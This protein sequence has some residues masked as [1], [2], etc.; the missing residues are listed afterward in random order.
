MAY[1]VAQAGSNWNKWK[2]MEIESGK[3]LEEELNWIKFGG[4]YLTLGGK[5]F[6][7]S[8]FPESGEGDEFHHL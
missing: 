1:G 7:Y 5:G 8:R 3:Q 2:I 4:V 6:F